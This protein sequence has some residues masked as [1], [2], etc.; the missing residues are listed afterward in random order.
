VPAG[1]IGGDPFTGR[2]IGPLGLIVVLV[3]AGIVIA[4]VRGSRGAT[5]GPS[6]TAAFGASVSTPAEAA[7][8]TALS[9]PVAPFLEPVPMRT[10]GDAG[11][12]RPESGGA[13]VG[14]SVPPHDAGSWAN[15]RTISIHVEQLD[16]PEE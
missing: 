14:D 8:M 16:T 7:E 1:S 11:T 5:A 3:I 2:L 13:P 10:G 4:R 15:A 6:A 9:D 12:V